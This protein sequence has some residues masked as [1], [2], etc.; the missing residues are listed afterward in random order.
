M[1]IGETL[2]TKYFGDYVEERDNPVTPQELVG[3]VKIS[4]KY[5]KYCRHTMAFLYCYHNGKTYDLPVFM[6][7]FEGETVAVLARVWQREVQDKVYNRLAV[8]AAKQ[9]ED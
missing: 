3:T 8:I 2:K 7:K 4:S 5:T 9:I 6:E 1:K